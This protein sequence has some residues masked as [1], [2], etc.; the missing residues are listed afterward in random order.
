MN[1]G[2]NEGLGHGAWRVLV[3]LFAIWM[4]AGALAP[5]AGA[6]GGESSELSDEPIP[7]KTED[8]LPGRTPPLIEIGPDFLGTGNIPR[9]F[10]LPTGA[11]W[12]PSLWVFGDYRTALNYFDNGEDPT[13]AEWV[14]RLDIFANLQLSGTERL[15]FGMEPLHDRDEFTGYIWKPSGRRDFERDGLNAEVR[16]LFFEGEFGEIFPDLDPDDTGSF[17]FGFAVGRQ[18]IFFQEGLL[19]AVD[20]GADTRQLLER[21]QDGLA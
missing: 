5:A 11:V 2:F 14:N 17:D 3:A 8:E 13:A 18:P 16:T 4:I 19:L 10:E 1:G 6:A 21:G 7:L 20:D 9:G 15:L 12:T